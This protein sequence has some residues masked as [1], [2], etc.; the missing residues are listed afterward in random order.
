MNSTS[1]TSI[2]SDGAGNGDKMANIDSS[3]TAHLTLNAAVTRP[4]TR[5]TRDSSNNSDSDPD[6]SPKVT[7]VTAPNNNTRHIHHHPFTRPAAQLV[8]GG[9]SLSN[10]FHM[11]KHHRNVWSGANSFEKLLML[12]ILVLAT[13]TL[14]LLIS[15]VTI[16]VSHQSHHDVRMAVEGNRTEQQPAS[17]SIERNNVSQPINRPSTPTNDTIVLI[18]DKE[19]KYCLTPNCVKVAASVIEAIDLTVDPCDDFYVSAATHQRLLARI[20]I[21][22]YRKPRMQIYVTFDLFPFIPSSQH[23]AQHER[24]WS[25]ESKPIY[26][27]IQLYSCGDWIKSNPLPDGKSNWGTFS[28]LWQDNQSIM[29]SVLGMHDKSNPETFFLVRPNRAR[30]SLL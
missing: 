6:R 7:V 14:L 21:Y 8:S 2:E 15:L 10:R 19:K 23:G 22:T 27:F 28:K 4:S 5:S 18:G 9:F 30:T 26:S 1:F 11:T 16:L 24:W 17:T 25:H 20:Y 3:S 13:T 12:A 29:R